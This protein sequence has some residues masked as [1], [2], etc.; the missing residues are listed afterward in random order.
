[1]NTCNY[2]HLIFNQE[3]KKKNTGEKRKYS[4]NCAEK[5]CIS[6]CRRKLERHLLPCTETN[7]K[8]IKD[9]NVKHETFKV[10]GANTGRTTW[11]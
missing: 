2:N 6:V 1:M 10:Q 9:I 4:T 8:L 7:S 3:A 11:Y 5:N